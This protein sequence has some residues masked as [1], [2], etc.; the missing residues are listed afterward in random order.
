MTSMEIIHSASLSSTESQHLE[1]LS[2]QTV[3]TGNQKNLKEN[4]PKKFVWSLVPLNK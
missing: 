3:T 2:L 1:L 4:P